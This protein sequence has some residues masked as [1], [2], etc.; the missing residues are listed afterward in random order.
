MICQVLC[1]IFVDAIFT[2]FNIIFYCFV[3]FCFVLLIVGIMIVVLF[4]LDSMLSLEVFNL[5][6]LYPLPVAPQKYY[7]T[8]S[9]FNLMQVYCCIF[10]CNGCLWCVSVRCCAP[11]NKHCFASICIR[12]PSSSFTAFIVSFDSLVPCAASYRNTLR[13]KCGKLSCSRVGVA[14]LW[15]DVMY[16]ILWFALLWRTRVIEFAAT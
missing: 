15:Y 10:G 4:L 5:F 16:T 2:L 13:W 6:V 9:H 14:V 12:L 11:P 8:N 1:F 3:N 7:S